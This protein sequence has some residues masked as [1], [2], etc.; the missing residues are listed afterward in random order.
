MRKH[1]RTY[2]IGG[3]RFVDFDLVHLQF[4][5]FLANCKLK[6]LCAI[7]KNQVWRVW[8]GIWDRTGS[9]ETEIAYVGDGLLFFPN[10]WLKNRFFQIFVRKIPL[11]EEIDVCVVLKS[12]WKIIF[13][14]LSRKQSKTYINILLQLRKV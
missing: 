8:D 6:Q 2:F 12:C 1:A 10:T 14:I 5:R 7:F 3:D 4:T 11:S 13:Q 9:T